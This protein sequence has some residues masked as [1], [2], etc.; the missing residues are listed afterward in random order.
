MEILL[1]ATVPGSVLRD[2]DQDGGQIPSKECT[3][4]I[5]MSPVDKKEIQSSVLNNGQWTVTN[6]LPF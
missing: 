6:W 3:K 4:K 5:F 2:V 1:A